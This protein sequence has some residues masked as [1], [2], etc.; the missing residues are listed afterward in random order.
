MPILLIYAF[1]S[2]AIIDE[3]LIEDRAIILGNTNLS[4]WANFRSTNASSGWSGLC[5][6]SKNPY[7]PT[8]NPCRSSSVSGIAMA[9]NLHS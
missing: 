1:L 9:A 2:N 5:G 6:Q 7:D 8:T 4:E 3:K